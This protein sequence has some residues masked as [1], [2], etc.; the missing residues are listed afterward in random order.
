MNTCGLSA[1]GGI[2]DDGTAGFLG[3]QWIDHNCFMTMLAEQEANAELKARLNC[4]AKRFRNAVAYDQPAK[5][6]QAYCVAFAKEIYLAEIA[7]QRQELIEAMEH[8][9]ALKEA[10][11]ARSESL[12]KP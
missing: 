4:E 5:E 12:P 3:F 11:L 1:D 2:G 8:E 10:G 6:R 7:E 9:L